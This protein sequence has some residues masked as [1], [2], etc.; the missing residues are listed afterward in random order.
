VGKEI[1]KADYRFSVILPIGASGKEAAS[2]VADADF[3]FSSADFDGELIFFNEGRNKEAEQTVV[4]LLPFV[5]NAFLLETGGKLSRY[6]LLEKAVAE[7]RG[8]LCLFI[9]PFI[10][11]RDSLLKLS[12]TLSAAEEGKIYVGCFGNENGFFPKSPFG[13]LA[14]R[15]AGF[16]GYP[17]L[18]AAPEALLCSS[19]QI[20]IKIFPKLRFKGK[21]LETEF[22]VLA[23]TENFPIE[24]IGLESTPGNRNRRSGRLAFLLLLAL[25]SLL[26]KRH[27]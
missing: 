14:D 12:R 22:V 27:L 1:R 4:S 24:K 18:D 16:F 10:F 19:R 15:L 9:N 11:S 8:R 21:W 17:G 26:G 13:R 25:K 7:A 2:A 3:A 6:S 23:T 5:R 20:F